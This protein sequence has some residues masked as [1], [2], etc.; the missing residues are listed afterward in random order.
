LVELAQ[1]PILCLLTSP[2]LLIHG[3]L[4]NLSRTTGHSIDE[5]G[6]E[7]IDQALQQASGIDHDRLRLIAGWFRCRQGSVVRW[8]GSA[9]IREQRRPDRAPRARH[10]LTQKP[11]WSIR[12]AASCCNWPAMKPLHEDLL[13]PVTTGVECAAA[14]AFT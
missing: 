10:P 14:I 11:G 8:F 13:P 2:S 9:V 6:M 5:V 7:L 3:Q 12:R 4:Q 1:A